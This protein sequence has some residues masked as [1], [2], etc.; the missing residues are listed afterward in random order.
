[1]QGFWKSSRNSVL[2]HRSLHFFFLLYFLYIYLCSPSVIK[3][4]WNYKH[5]WHPIVSNSFCS[6]TLGPLANKSSAPGRHPLGWCLQQVRSRGWDPTAALC[7]SDVSSHLG[8]DALWA[9]P[10]TGWP[11]RRA[12]HR[13][14]CLGTA[15]VLGTA[16]AH[17]RV[18]PQANHNLLLDVRA[19]VWMSAKREKQKKKKKKKNR[20]K[21]NQKRKPV[22]SLHFRLVIKPSHS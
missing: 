19:S 16:C 13:D 17:G 3:K 21:E 20:K 2:L 6:D 12:Q 22:D 4:D 11:C 15:A 7:S 10:H 9:R 1:M 14:A 18:D 8:C 5:V